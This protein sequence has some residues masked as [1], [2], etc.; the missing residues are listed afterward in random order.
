M[1]SMSSIPGHRS[2]QPTLGLAALGICTH[3]GSVSCSWGECPCLGN[4]Q[5]V[6]QYDISSTPGLGETARLYRGP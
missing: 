2:F 5:M 4:G 6:A 3:L 1:C